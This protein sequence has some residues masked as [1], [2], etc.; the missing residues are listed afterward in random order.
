V[1]ILLKYS[2]Y[3]RKSVLKLYIDSCLNDDCLQK[4]DTIIDVTVVSFDLNNKK[5]EFAIM[6]VNS[7][8]WY[9]SLRCPFPFISTG[10]I[11]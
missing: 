6:I 2:V 8:N 9:N 1:R 11:F 4:F 7:N 5:F 3:C 10:N